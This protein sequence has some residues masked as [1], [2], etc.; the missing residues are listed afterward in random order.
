[1]VTALT[2]IQ[3]QLLSLPGNWASVLRVHH[4]SQFP[5][6]QTERVEKF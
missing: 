6:L 5:S 1:M 3:I 2:G 4:M